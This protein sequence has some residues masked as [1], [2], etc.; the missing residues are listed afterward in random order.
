MFIMT[1][2]IDGTDITTGTP[3]IEQAMVSLYDGEPVTLAFTSAREDAPGHLCTA[4]GEFI[5]P[6]QSPPYWT[7]TEPAYEHAPTYC[8]N[9]LDYLACRTCGETIEPADGGWVHTD[10]AGNGGHV[11]EPDPEDL[12]TEDRG[13]ASPAP[14]D[15]FNSASLTV[16]PADD[17]VTAEIDGHHLTVRRVQPN[18]AGPSLIVHTPYP[19]AHSLQGLIPMHPGTFREAPYPAG[20]DL[21]PLWIT[22]DERAAL[23]RA[24]AM[25]RG[26]TET[27]GPNPLRPVETDELAAKIRRA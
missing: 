22:R 11:A 21:I 5:E 6:H 20:S 13:T 14:L 1:P 17:A 19:G 12:A 4:C 24:V 23:E 26:E 8:A 18:D 25:S 15:W 16:E 9:A 3:A 2:R 27:H 7:H 10:D